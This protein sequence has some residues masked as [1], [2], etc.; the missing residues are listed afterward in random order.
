MPQRY[1]VE[2]RVI[3]SDWEPDVYESPNPFLPI[4]V[5]DFIVLGAGSPH[6]R[7]RVRDV[8]HTIVTNTDGLVEQHKMTVRGDE[9][10]PFVLDATMPRLTRPSDSSATNH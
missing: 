1:V 5:G 9:I 2:V 10:R 7:V 8:E 6:R 4:T 3:D